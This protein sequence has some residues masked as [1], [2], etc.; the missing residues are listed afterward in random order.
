MVN[1]PPLL[2]QRHDVR[3]SRFSEDDAGSAL[4]HVGRAADGDADFGLAERWSVVDAVAC[5]AGHVPRS[6]QVFH[7]GVFVL[8]KYFRETIRARE[9][10]NRLVASLQ[11]RH[12]ADVGQP[13]SLADFT[14]H[15]QCVAGEHLYRN[16]EIVERGDELLGVRPRRIIQ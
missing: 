2:D 11:I 6:L 7:D 1:R 14:R 9:Q 3:Q 8:R 10:I 15:R 5:H 4:G 16:A 12:V 13:D